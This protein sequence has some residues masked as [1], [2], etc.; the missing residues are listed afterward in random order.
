[1]P[2]RF[3]NSPTILSLFLVLVI[4]VGLLIGLTVRPGE[5]YDSLNKPVFNPPNW[6]FGPAWTIL[7]ILIAIAGW[8]TWLSGDFKRAP[9]RIWVSQMILNWMWTPLFFGWH[10]MYYSLAVILS[11]LVVILCFI[12]V[13][14]DGIARASFVPYA[15]WVGFA[16][17]LNASLI[18]L[19]G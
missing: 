12:V 16:S 1:M 11:L 7:Y 6:V 5:W 19:N 4:G 14:R 8:R 17:L 15:L 13:S 9:G 18:W 2:S 3:R 10:A